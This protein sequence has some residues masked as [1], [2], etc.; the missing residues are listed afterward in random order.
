MKRFPSGAGSYL[1][2]ECDFFFKKQMSLHRND[3]GEK[4]G[5]LLLFARSTNEEEEAVR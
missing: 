2:I 3:D 5:H 4:H 1:V